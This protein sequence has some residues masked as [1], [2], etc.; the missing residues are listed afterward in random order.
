MKNAFRFKQFEIDQTGCAMRINTDG[1]LLGAVAGKNEAAN[2][3]DIGTGTGVIALMLAQRFPNALV[4]AVEIDEQAALT[5]TKNAL[6]APFSGRLKVLHSAI[7]DYLPEKYYDLIVSNPPYFVNDL[8]NPEHR[9]GV[10]RHTDAHFF[11]Q[12]L[13]RVAAM[14]SRN[15]RF[16][17]ILPLKQAQNIVD[18][19]KLYGL[20]MAVVLHIHSD[21]N[22]PEI[23]QIVCLDYSGQPAHHHNLYIYA[24]KG[25]YTDAYKVLLKDFFLAF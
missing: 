23:R 9:K 3:L 10:A 4:D 11:E 8:K 19:A 18:M 6:N 7:E 1:V 15:G 2:I 16:W 21:E 14:L 17:F 12:L 5:A 25:L 24:G 22:K 13:E 20:G